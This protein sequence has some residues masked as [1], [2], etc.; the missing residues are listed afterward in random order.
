MKTLPIQFLEL[1]RYLKLHDINAYL[2]GSSSRDFLLGNNIEDY[3]IA[4]DKPID[5][6]LPLFEDK[7]D[8]YACYGSIVVKF[9][10]VKFDIT[11]FR[12][13][14]QYID[15]RHP[16]HIEFTS[17]MREDFIR[18]DF[19]INA[20]YIDAEGNVFDFSSG[21]IDLSSHLIRMIGDPRKRIKEDP[22]RI[23]RAIRFSLIYDFDIEESLEFAIKRFGSLLSG[24]SQGKIDSE[25]NKMRKANVNEME[26]KKAFS[27]FNINMY[28][29]AK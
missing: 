24:I 1:A 3:D 2:I 14:K 26:I 22:L 6:L 9:N 13:E 27:K 17:D 18:R 11:S 12:K 8:K 28:Y 23:L 10:D 4:V 29:R 16:A 19:S 21:L 20:I 25:L 7:M 5:L 15:H